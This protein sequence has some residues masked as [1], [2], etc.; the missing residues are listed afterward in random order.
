[1][2]AG[3]PR[4]WFAASRLLCTVGPSGCT[5]PPVSDDPELRRVSELLDR[6]TRGE[7]SEAETE[8]LEL[9]AAA[10]PELRAV[11]EARSR[12][13]VL[14]GGWLVRVE[15]EHALARAER[16]P[17]VLAVRGAALAMLLA[18]LFAASAAPLVGAG[19]LVVGLAV[20]LFSW[21]RVNHRHD[22]YKDIQR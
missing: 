15:A 11:I 16:S 6:L 12:Q 9:Y 19:L 1:M 20:L 21:I 17:G 3:P 4:S 14:G 5:I 22:P 18:G 13:A 7:L 10:D 8:E 2:S